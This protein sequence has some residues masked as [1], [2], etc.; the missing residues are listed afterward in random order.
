[1]S[2]Y[3]TIIDAIATDLTTNVT[4]LATAN[5]N[6][7]LAVHKYTPLTIERMQKDGFRHLAVWLAPDQPAVLNNQQPQTGI[8]NHSARFE[9]AYWEP[10][11]EG[12]KGVADETA[13]T[14]ILTLNDAFLTRFYQTT[15]QT[16]GSSAGQW[17]MWFE[18]M[19]PLIGGDHPVRALVYTLVGNVEYQFS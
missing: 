12:E 16:V 7:Q 13:A 5:T 3:S 8:H 2:V 9:V 14:T 19:T 15:F 17:R 10:S 11:P 4:T 18:S 6:N 1:M